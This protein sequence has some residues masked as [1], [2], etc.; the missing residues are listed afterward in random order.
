MN[1]SPKAVTAFLLPFVAALVLYL[2]TKDQTYLVGL[3]IAVA[4][5]GGAAIAP[6]A[7]GVK[8]EDVSAVARGE[9]KIVATEDLPPHLK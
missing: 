4:T 5:G 8:Q 7:G 3:L 2:V 6:P 9:A 1:I